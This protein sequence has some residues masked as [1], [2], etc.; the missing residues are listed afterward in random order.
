MCLKLYK[1]KYINNIMTSKHK[2]IDME[3]NVLIVEKNASIKEILLNN[4]TNEEYFYKIIGLKNPDKEFKKYSSWEVEI[5]KKKYYISV[6]AKENGRSGQENKYEFPPPIDNNLFF[7]SC[8]IVN[9]DKTGKKIKNLTKD[10]WN[11]IYENLYGGFEDIDEDE[12]EE[13]EEDEDEDEDED[14]DIEKTKEGYDKDGFIVDDEEEEDEEEEEEE[15]DDEEDDE[16]EDDENDEDIKVKV[17]KKIQKIKKSIKKVIEP[18]KSVLEDT[19]L[20][21]TSELEMEEYEN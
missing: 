8:L 15:D 9:Y 11:L 2:L 16:E 5:E 10:E 6:Y 17:Q 12:E 3:V 19:Y 14:D 20:D 13:E 18:P 1:H 7:G 4:L 21:C